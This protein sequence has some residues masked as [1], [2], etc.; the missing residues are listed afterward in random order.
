MRKVYKVM[1]GTLREVTDIGSIEG[2]TEPMYNG[3]QG[4]GRHWGKGRKSQSSWPEV[5]GIFF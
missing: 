4:Q 1:K 5:A 2:S 3:S